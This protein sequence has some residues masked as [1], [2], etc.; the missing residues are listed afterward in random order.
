MP[1][2]EKE[3]LAAEKCSKKPTDEEE[4]KLVK[5]IEEKPTHAEPDADNAGGPSDNDEDNE[6][7]EEKKK[8]CKKGEGNVNPAESEAN[9]AGSQATSTGDMMG[10]GQHVLVPQSGISV[11]REQAPMGKSVD[12]E[13]LMKSPLFVN[14]TK[15]MDAM[16]DALGKKVDALQKSVD[17]RLANIKKDLEVAEKGLKEFYGQSFHKAL[18][19]SVGPEGV[20]SQTFEKQ[21]AAGV[22]RFRSK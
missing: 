18:G 3:K 6:T 2:K 13:M 20:Q 5:D 21:M 17:D 7:E 19:E 9:G 8:K 22:I 15:Q 12:S 4:G 14:I 10:G 16:Q 1:D 11:S